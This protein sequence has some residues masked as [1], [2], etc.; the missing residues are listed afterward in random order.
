[1]RSRVFNLTYLHCRWCR[2]DW[3]VV[4]RWIT[5]ELCRMPDFADHT[6]R[7]YLVDQV[8]RR[9]LIGLTRRVFRIR[10]FPRLPNLSLNLTDH[11]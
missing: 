6:P 3:L 5:T 4:D 1:V 7:R 8:E 2:D 11:S 10:M 9:V